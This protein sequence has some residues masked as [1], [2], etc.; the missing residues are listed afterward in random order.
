MHDL[1][2]TLRQW[3]G[4][5]AQPSAAIYDARTLQSSPESGERGGYDG[6]KKRQGSKV[7][8][9]VDTLGHLLTLLVTPANEQDRAQVA[10]LSKAVQAVTQERVEIAFVEQG[11]TGSEAEQA[12]AQEGIALCVVNLP[13]PRRALFCCPGAGRSARSA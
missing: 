4:R 11:Y 1:R 5:A 10:E 12:A 2:E 13:R 8:M 7:H 3:Q 6:A 9:A